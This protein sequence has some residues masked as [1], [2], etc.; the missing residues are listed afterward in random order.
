M[1]N[2]VIIGGSVHNFKGGV[3]EI[4]SRPPS[5]RADGINLVTPSE[6]LLKEILTV[7]TD[8]SVPAVEIPS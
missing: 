8:S 6:H 2:I 3:D 1:V 7:L 5:G 4:A